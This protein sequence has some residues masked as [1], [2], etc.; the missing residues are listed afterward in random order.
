[1]NL[2]WGADEMAVCDAPPRA[3]DLDIEGA[4]LLIPGDPE[5]SLLSVRIRSLGD[6]R[7]PSVGSARVDVEGAALV[8]EWIAAAT[9]CPSLQ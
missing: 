4:A 3:G 2:L 1:M 8:D 9:D 5:R 6:A 7:M